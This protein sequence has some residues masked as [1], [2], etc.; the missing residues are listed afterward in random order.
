MNKY[1]ITGFSGFVSRHFIEYLVSLNI[2]I[3]ILG[4]DI[5]NPEFD[6]SNYKNINCKFKKV[7][8]LDADDVESIIYNFQPNYILHLASYSS[9][10]YSWQN[11]ANSFKNNT[12]IFL[13]L[14]EKV[15]LLGLNCRII[16]VGSSEEYGIV[17]KKELPLKEI[18]KLNPSSP[19]AVARVAQEQLS[20]VYVE[21]FGLD[22][23]ITRSFNHIGP[24][25]KDIFAIPSFVKQLVE[26]K[27]GNKER[28]LVTGN[29]SVIRDFVDVRDVVRAYY[30]L[31]IKG[32]KGEIYNICSGEGNSLESIINIIT[33]KLNI[34]I[35][36]KI[37]P[38]RIRPNDNSIILGSFE[39]LNKLTGWKPE[40]EIKKSITDIIDYWQKY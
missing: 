1:L 14:I 6:Y 9:V 17:N 27:R 31:F 22:I 19:Y 8:L 11:P 21:G 2:K 15:R 16:S 35:K 7:N 18:N 10:G 26:I 30:L 4:L 23:I 13:T 40:I 12:N 20:K 37:D 33:E 32:G 36:I 3:Q 25:Q 29:I 24:Y 38:Q 34:D 28:K 39:K 5:N